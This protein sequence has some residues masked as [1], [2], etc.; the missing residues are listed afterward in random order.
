MKHRPYLH[1][2]FKIYMTKKDFQDFVINESYHAF[3]ACLG[4]ILGQKG[5]LWRIIKS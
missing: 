1:K 5:A 2:Y 4:S 3:T